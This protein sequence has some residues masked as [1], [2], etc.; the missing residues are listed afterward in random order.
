MSNTTPDPSNGTGS[1]P[2]RGTD[3]PYVLSSA[4]LTMSVVA[5]TPQSLNGGTTFESALALKFDIAS[6]PQ[7]VPLD[8]VKDLVPG[9]PAKPM[10]GA[11]HSNGSGTGPVFVEGV[12][13][14]MD[15]EL[16]SDAATLT[17]SQNTIGIPALKV[18]WVIG[19]LDI[20]I[21]TDT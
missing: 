10:I 12:E 13:F 6:T 21:D 18:E 17:V 19:L 20:D 14:T 16:S 1:V 3:N 7:I 11:R 15:V 2:I 5:T 9:G 8:V 4:P